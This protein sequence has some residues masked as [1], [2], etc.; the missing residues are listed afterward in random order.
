M[1]TLDQV[2]NEV[3]KKYGH[4]SFIEFKN[5]CHKNAH[6]LSDMISMFE[7]INK[8]YAQSCCE[9]VRQRCADNASIMLTLHDKNVLRAILNTEII[10]P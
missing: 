3:C 7:E 6:G 1:K 2:K 5:K 9:D 8:E 4:N 10:L